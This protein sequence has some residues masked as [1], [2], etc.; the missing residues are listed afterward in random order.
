MPINSF[1]FFNDFP[2]IIILLCSTKGFAIFNISNFSNP[3]KINFTKVEYNFYG[4]PNRVN[5]LNLKSNIFVFGCSNYGI[6]I[7]N[8]SNFKN[9]ELISNATNNVM[10]EIRS[11]D[12]SKNDKYCFVTV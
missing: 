3:Y 5:E 8:I 9:P 6:L 4:D 11:L 2:G 10:G 12:I 7:Y 1:S